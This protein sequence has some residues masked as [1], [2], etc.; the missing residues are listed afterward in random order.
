MEWQR[1]CGFPGVSEGF[2]Q[3]PHVLPKEDLEIF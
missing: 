1:T 2:I 3:S